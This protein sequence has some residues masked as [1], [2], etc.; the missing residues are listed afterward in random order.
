MKG[1]GPPPI[2]LTP[3]PRQSRNITQLGQTNRGRSEKKKK[4]MKKKNYGTSLWIRCGEH[5]TQRKR[6]D[7]HS[8]PGSTR[9]LRLPLQRYHRSV[10]PALPSPWSSPAAPRRHGHRLLHRPVPEDPDPARGH[11]SWPCSHSLPSLALSP[12]SQSQN[13]SAWRAFLGF[14][15]PLVMAISRCGFGS[16]FAAIETV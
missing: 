5:L 10:A 6:E 14:C 12:A 15:P 2:W 16:H 7:G 1:T 3:L 13:P 8:A 11:G 4:E 9:L